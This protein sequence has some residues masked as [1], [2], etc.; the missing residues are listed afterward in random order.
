[1]HE[2][3]DLVEKIHRA[4]AEDYIL[5]TAA[6]EKLLAAIRGTTHAEATA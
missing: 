6:S 2:D 4:G 1:M 5:K 3:P